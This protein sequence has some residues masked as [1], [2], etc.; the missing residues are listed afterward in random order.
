[1]KLGDTS[2]TFFAFLLKY[3]PKKPLYLGN[4]VGVIIT[5]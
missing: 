4:K 3:V 2:Y 1:M 5:L